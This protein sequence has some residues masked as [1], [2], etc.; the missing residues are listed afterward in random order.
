[1]PED[2]YWLVTRLLEV[3]QEDQAT[4][5]RSEVEA[6][7]GDRISR[8]EVERLLAVASER[9]PARA[10]STP[11]PGGRSPIDDFRC[12][13]DAVPS[14][15]ELC[16][17]LNTLA[18]T[19]DPQV[20]LEAVRSAFVGCLGFEQRSLDETARLTTTGSI[21][22]LLLV[23]DHA[24]FV[25]SF[26]EVVH[27]GAY[28]SALAPVFRFHPYGLVVAFS[29]GTNTCRLVYRRLSGSREGEL[30]LRTLVGGRVGREPY[31]NLLVWAK[32][33]D[34][35][36]P[37]FGD[38][39]AALM[40]R[41]EAVLWLP[42]VE[43]ARRWPSAPV[44]ETDPLPGTRWPE[45]AG[46]GLDAFLQARA[47]PA[48]RLFWGL[49]RVLRDRF[50]MPIAA[51]AA[52]LH[53]ERYGVT[54]APDD[55]EQAWAEERTWAHRVALR[56]R[57][58]P[59]SGPDPGAEP[60]ILEAGVPALDEAGCFLV[61]GQLM[62]FVPEVH[63]DGSLWRRLPEEELREIDEDTLLDLGPAGAPPTLAP[64]TAEEESGADGP[65]A[66]AD[67]DGPG[68]DDSG[69]PEILG[70]ASTC[71]LLEVAA[72]RKLGALAVQLWR[73][74][75]GAD[76]RALAWP[77][78]KL[79]GR[80]PVFLL[81]S[82]VFLRAVLEPVRRPSRPACTLPVL[83]QARG[84]EARTAPA[85]ACPDVSADL[86]SSTW[87]PVA[88]ARL[89]PVGGL[90][91]PHRDQAGAV[92]LGPPA[93]PP[94][95]ANARC[96]GAGPGPALWWIA[97]GLGPYAALP[98]GG[99]GAPAAVAAWSQDVS[100]PH[101]LRVPGERLRARVARQHLPGPQRRSVRLRV[102]IPDSFGSEELP[103]PR[104]LAAV[105]VCVQ[106][107]DAWLSA[108]S[109]SW[110]RPESAS[111]PPPLRRLLG[112][113]ME[114]EPHG[115]AAREVWRV[116][117]GLGG[118]VVG[119]SLHPVR[120]RFGVRLGWNACLTVRPRA[121]ST[122]DLGHLVLPDGRLAPIVAPLPPEDAPCLTDGT[123]AGAVVEDPSV[124]A[125]GGA[126]AGWTDGRT[127][128][129]VAAA[130]EVVGGLR[131]V[132]PPGGPAVLA[133][134]WW[135]HFRRRDG[136]GIPGHPTSPALSAGD[137]RGGAARG[138]GGW[139]AVAES[140]RAWA[141]GEPP[142]WGALRQVLRAGRLERGAPPA[143]P[144]R[145][146][147]RRVWSASEP[148]ATRF[149]GSSSHGG[150]P[151]DDRVAWRCDCGE[152]TGAAR[153]C[154]PCARCGRR[155]LPRAAAQGR[156][157][158]LRLPEPVVHPWWMGAAAAL[159]GQTEEELRAML[160][161][162]GTA[163]VRSW[164]RGASDRP[165][166]AAERRL[167]DGL[168]HQ[169]AVRLG[170]GV[171]RLRTLVEH[172]GWFERLFLDEVLVLPEGLLP[173]GL[174]RRGPGVLAA[175]LRYA[176][177][178]VHWAMR[179][180]RPWR[181]RT[182]SAPVAAARQGLQEAVDALFGPTPA[183]PNPGEDGSLSGLL[184]RL[185]PLT[186]A[187]GLRSV[188]PGTFALRGE[189]ASTGESD[190]HEVLLRSIA[191]GSPRSADPASADL[192]LVEEEVPVAWR[193][194]PRP[195]IRLGVVT[196]EGPRMAPARPSAPLP[197]DAPDSWWRRR[198]ALAAWTSTLLP[199]V[200]VMLT[201]PDPAA[202]PD[203]D[204]RLALAALAA[205]LESPV[206]QPERLHGVLLRRLPWMLPSDDHAACSQVA[207]LVEQAFPGDD[208]ALR[209]ARDDLVLVLAGWWRVAPSID[210]PVGWRW[211]P[212]GRPA[213]RG[214]RRALPPLGSPAW[215]I[216]PGFGAV[217]CPVEWFWEAGCEP[218]AWP[219]LIRHLVGIRT[220]ELPRP[221]AERPSGQVAVGP[222]A[223]SA[224]VAT[225]RDALPE[226]D[227]AVDGRVPGGE[228]D[229][230]ANEGGQVTPDDGDGTTVVPDVR[231]LRVRLIDWLREDEAR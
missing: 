80:D 152:V 205:A 92:R 155:A 54:A 138:A 195:T 226:Q 94:S 50:P 140:E 208:A 170:R 131:V 171:Q 182:W 6:R 89:D 74:E 28:A 229:R 145:G 72:A 146:G 120:G 84:C 168:G 228:Q 40:L 199:F 32:R 125:A 37:R 220:G 70:G 150:L 20:A 219:A 210:D 176:Y 213:S 224:L 75:D 63:E 188:V 127:G 197:S 106:P 189:P 154:E 207:A 7:G 175:P 30:W 67:A 190:A 98:P 58:G 103:A 12:W 73:L 96:G 114:V 167:H 9:A 88:S 110:L 34:L 109:E 21:R 231:R 177:R 13:L 187:A 160:H 79:R 4:R 216:W 65:E 153:A 124:S 142:W 133:P 57:L 105:G 43:I 139:S 25:V 230:P 137:R 45:V 93:D 115:R 71:T 163:A 102:R 215:R 66:K 91:V 3:L 76:A 209:R 181:G 225:A 24:G 191:F 179:R 227:V 85:W 164:L 223:E 18:L 38:D 86:P 158:M 100:I 183:W 48:E 8:Q 119:A 14:G 69:G 42:A 36:R 41:A 90:T 60:L 26:A 206:S 17:A 59:A 198:D 5:L 169:T 157:G 135:L 217:V 141:G 83:R 222:P 39:A 35:L 204:P 180:L 78:S 144:S 117:P 47:H 174:P 172:S 128:E 101:V 52:W 19:R 148:M 149:V 122:G 29:P 193:A 151:D 134:D 143:E 186:R 165:F 212:T 15:P 202:P 44:S 132:P 56:L 200:G 64:E 196:A 104:L 178:R 121:G 111:R 49:E 194:A 162:L 159:G 118:L 16:A 95:E 166:E 27:S 81:A 107:G 77:I 68:L 53:Y 211:L 87:L 116:P 108:S 184:A 55:R 156:P 11:G 147:G 123:P 51:G 203:R 161:S 33:L 126:P 173:A 62:C 2:L 113:V 31:D 112:S 46:R 10:R 218:S 221:S 22:R 201:A 192:A 130:V 1:M 185:W 61:D 82:R 23:G 99:L 129:P 136:E 97:E 214:A